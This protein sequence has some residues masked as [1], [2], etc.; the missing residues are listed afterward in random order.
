MQLLG[1]RIHNTSRAFQKPILWM[2]VV[3][4]MLSAV[5][6]NTFSVQAQNSNC[7][8]ENGTLKCDT[9]GS[10][11][12]P[13]PPPPPPPPGGGGGGTAIPGGGG[14]PPPSGGTPS[15]GGTAPP[16]SGA[17]PAPPGNC[18]APCSVTVIPGSQSSAIIVL[19]CVSHGNNSF[20]KDTYIVYYG[21]GAGSFLLSSVAMNP[22]DC[23][24]APPSTPPPSVEKP[25]ATPV[26]G[27]GGITINCNQGNGHTWAYNIA[28]QVSCPINEVLREPYPRTLVTLS[29]R[30][31]LLPNQQYNEA[32]SPRGDMSD[33]Y[34]YEVVPVA[35][36]DKGIEVGDP[37]HDGE[38]RNIHIGVRAQRK[39]AFSAWIGQTVPDSLFEFQDRD[40]NGGHR[41]YDTSQRGSVVAFEYETSSWGLPTG[42][43]AFDF[44][45]Q[46]PADND[47]SLPAY[48]ANVTSYC[49][50]EWNIT[51]EYSAGEEHTFESCRFYG[52]PI[53]SNT[54][55]CGAGNGWAQAVGTIY[56]W[57]NYELGWTPVDARLSGYANTYVP[58]QGVK[59]GGK[60]KG[61]TYWDTGGPGGIRIPVVEVQSVL[62]E[63][64]VYDGS[65]QPPTA[66]EQFLSKP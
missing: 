65:C 16:P 50:F 7:R 5:F 64:C 43:R 38:F 8:I 15:P 30:F 11:G 3:A 62:R 19:A 61:Q 10:G 59:S 24:A 52:L 4:L 32:W 49:G 63:P 44:T 18:T 28:A 60:F 42:G 12:T 66:E 33:P 41:Q 6:T 31:T 55:S 27:N 14:T 46:R 36:P 26:I 1:I 45:Q 2:I 54:R 47:Y 34:F 51:W 40:W 35:D 20:T 25:C 56:K 9:G 21:A 17:T 58:M 48:T 37:K 22:A 57:H 39:P 13:P 53:P 29:T 23:G